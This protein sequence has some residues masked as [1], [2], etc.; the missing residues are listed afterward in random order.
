MWKVSEVIFS[1]TLLMSLIN[2]FICMLW[3][4]THFRIIL[5][6]CCPL[7]ESVVL[8][9]NKLNYL[10]S[11]FFLPLITGVSRIQELQWCHFGYPENILI[12]QDSA[13]PVGLFYV[14]IIVALLKQNPDPSQKPDSKIHIDVATDP[15]LDLIIFAW[16]MGQKP[17]LQRP[18][19]SRKHFTW[20]SVA[21]EAFVWIWFNM[22]IV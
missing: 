10:W 2:N 14:I 16:T 17:R 9:W 18:A 15:F 8:L 12:K 3:I 19:V 4:E 7:L 13:G 21:L 5:Q 11:V 22:C 20:I 1:L 6:K